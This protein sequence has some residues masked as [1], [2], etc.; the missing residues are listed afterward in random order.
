MNFIEYFTINVGTRV[1]LRP[2]Q[3]GFLGETAHEVDLL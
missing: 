2:L 3:T 1:F